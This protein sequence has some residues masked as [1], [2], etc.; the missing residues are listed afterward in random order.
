MIHGLSPPLTNDLA[1][2]K[3]ALSFDGRQAKANI[4]ASRG[5]VKRSEVSC[6]LPVKGLTAHEF[7]NGRC[8]LFGLVHADRVR[9]VAN[10]H[11]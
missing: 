10:E 9:G 7:P 8:V 6:R 5:N 1:V 3:T 4:I 11:G 2:T